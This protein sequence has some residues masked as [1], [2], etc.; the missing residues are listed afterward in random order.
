VF[1]EIIPSEIGIIY[2]KNQALNNFDGYLIFA[3]LSMCK[4]SKRCSA[5]IWVYDLL[6][7]L[8]LRNLASYE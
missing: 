1:G 2:P 8:F 6:T 5:R 3:K 4:V 7:F